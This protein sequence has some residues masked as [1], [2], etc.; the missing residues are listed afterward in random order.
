MTGMK[1]I[2]HS[3]D[4]RLIKLNLRVKQLEQEKKIN[5]SWNR[6]KEAFFTSPRSTQQPASTQQNTLKRHLYADILN[7]GLQYAGSKLAAF[8]GQWVASSLQNRMDKL[9]LKILTGNRKKNT[10]K[11][12]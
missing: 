9:I 2:K 11:N 10:V 5:Q 4:I 8:A 3:G 1:K 7:Y 12:K 6:V